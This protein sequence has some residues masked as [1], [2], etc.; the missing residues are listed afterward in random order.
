M[1]AAGLV[2]RDI[3][4][5]N[6]MLAD[7][8]RVVL[9]DFGTGRE[10]EDRSASDLAGTPIYVAP[11][12]LDGQSCD[13]PERRLQPR[14]SALPSPHPVL[15]CAGTESS[16]TFA[17]HTTRTRVRRFAPLGPMRRL[18]SRASIDRAINPA[19]DRRYTSAAA[20]GAALRDAHRGSD[21]ARRPLYAGVVAAMA[22]AWRRRP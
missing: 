2:H 7:D 3:K 10:L 15:P 20:F 12:V 13:G 22:R 18:L 1:H 16:A 9:M 6:V 14:G 11:E 17:R 4:A 21:A 5:Q 19:L 8:G